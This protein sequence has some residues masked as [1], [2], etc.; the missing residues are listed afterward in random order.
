MV[1]EHVKCAV[2]L[3]RGRT[4]VGVLEE[5][6]RSTRAVGQSS[7]E[8]PRVAAPPGE[9]VCNLN[10]FCQKEPP[11]EW[12][13]PFFFPTQ[14]SGTFGKECFLWFGAHSPRARPTCKGLPG[15][16]ARRGKEAA[17]SGPLAERT[18]IT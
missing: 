17:L 6:E 10:V 4:K 3:E 7:C 8:A 5:K 15:S 13:Q 16:R 18:L 12:L 9:C 11:P 1:G 14:L 2:E